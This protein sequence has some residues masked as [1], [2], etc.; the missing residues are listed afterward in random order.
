[1]TA[2][3][4]RRRGAAEDA[5]RTTMQHQGP[6]RDGYIGCPW[7]SRARLLGVLRSA[8]CSAGAGARLLRRLVDAGELQV[9]G[10]PGELEYRW[11]IDSGQATSTAARPTSPRGESGTVDRPTAA[12]PP[13]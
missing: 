7:M 4:D 9:R 8:G 12:D 10:E 2:A 6:A 5:L 13:L 11:P 1:M 3:T